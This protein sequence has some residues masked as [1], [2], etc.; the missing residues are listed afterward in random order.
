MVVQHETVL[1]LSASLASPESGTSPF[2]EKTLE[3]KVSHVIRTPR[4]G[5]SNL[6]LTSEKFY[7]AYSLTT[8]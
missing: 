5:V 3:L 2:S 7:D 1:V 8:A 6:K 4:G